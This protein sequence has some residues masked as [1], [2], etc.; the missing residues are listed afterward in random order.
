MRIIKYLFAATLFLTIIGGI[1][2]FVGSIDRDGYDDLG[3][4]EIFKELSDERNGFREIA[5]TQKKGFRGIPTGMNTETLRKHVKQEGWDHAAVTS[6]VET[7]AEDI[8]NVVKVTEYDR[9]QFPVG[10]NVLEGLPI[11]GPIVDASRLLVVSSMQKVR[12]AN[13]AQAIFLAGKAAHFAQ[14]VKTEENYWLISHMIGLAMQHESI[15]WIHHLANNYELEPSQYAA[16]SISLEPIPSYHDDKFKNMFSGEFNFSMRHLQDTNNRPFTERWDDWWYDNEGWD[17]DINGDEGSA[18]SFSPEDALYFVHMLF[19]RF[20]IHANEDAHQ[21]AKFYSKLSVLAESY[22]SVSDYPS[23]AE[24][25]TPSWT[26]ILKPNSMMKLWRRNELDFAGFYIRRCFGHAH[27][28]STKAIVAIKHYEAE[29]GT[30]PNSLDELVPSYLN[31]LPVDPFSGGPMGYSKENA[32]LYSVGTNFSDDG[33]SKS[34]YYIRRCENN[35][36]CKVNP[37]FPF[38]PSS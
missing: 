34:G 12:L 21:A 19:P 18:A 7:H 25:Y 17:D 30:L 26:D 15:A 33:G 16:L 6:L 28:E 37:T 9:F 13:F 38:V 1:W 32:W 29:T 4:T 14:Q 11:Y 22:C 10:E 3:L 2:I 24:S 23:K 31:S 20:T 35:E 8:N 36:R 5:Y 27:I